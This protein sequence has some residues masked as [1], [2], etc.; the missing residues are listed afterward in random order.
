MSAPVLMISRNSSNVWPP[1]GK[2]RVVRRQIA[3]NNVR[4]IWNQSAEIPAPAQVDS[5][6]ENLRLAHKRVST[7]GVLS[8]GA[9]AVAVVAAN[10]NV[11]KVAP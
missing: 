9:G 2:T 4:R 1:T 11:D 7:G 8:S 10:L 3:G 6:I 5:R